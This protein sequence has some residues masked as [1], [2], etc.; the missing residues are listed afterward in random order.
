MK[1]IS[2]NIFY[3][4][5]I[6]F[7]VFLL[8]SFIYKDFTYISWCEDLFEPHWACTNLNPFSDINVFSNNPHHSLLY[9]M[10]YNLM[11]VYLPRILN[12]HPLTCFENITSYFYCFILITLLMVISLNFSI[13]FKKYKFII[14]FIIALLF[15][16]AYIAIN[17][18]STMYYIYYSRSW[19]CGYFI[20]PVFV[21]VLFLEFSKHFILE[22]Q[23]TRRNMI[24][25]VLL[26]LC[27][28][29][30]FE[31]LRYI[32]LTFLIIRIF[33]YIVAE[34][35]KVNLKKYLILL[36]AYIVF[37]FIL[38]LLC[39]GSSYIH[40]INLHTD[41]QLLIHYFRDFF[42]SYYHYIIYNNSVTLIIT[43]I[44]F[45][46]IFFFVKD[47]DRK[48][49]FY[50]YTGS[51][52]TAVFSYPLMTIFFNFNPEGWQYDSYFHYACDH[53]GT[54]YVTAIFMVCIL[55]SSFGF[56]ISHAQKLKYKIISSVILI[57]ALIPS[58]AFF[59]R[60]HFG[61]WYQLINEPE[62]TKFFKERRLNLY[63]LEKFYAMYGV[64]NNVFYTYSP[65]NVTY[66][67]NMIMYLLLL[68]SE[69]NKLGRNIPEAVDYRII[70]VCSDDDDLFTV[71]KDKML[72]TVKEKTGYV[73]TDEE[74]INTDFDS[75][76]DY[77]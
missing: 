28:A 37:N 17:D 1:K 12:I 57:F 69:N 54:R 59:V 58:Y 63:I 25:L 68:Y 47:N 20:L 4:L 15:F 23:L 22:Q 32:V 2:L 16:P 52:I 34:K 19:M 38:V 33:L 44:I 24:T 21:I 26:L 56:L 67:D 64:K 42:R 29:N 46:L 31:I 55:L 60:N 39:R 35:E 43:T 11:E 9:S 6:L 36:S 27:I 45:V 49:K 70:H 13:F 66:Y 10:P 41:P 48:N 3:I 30:S 75:I 71:C 61:T 53:L 5:I 62:F 40:F 18:L 8:H 50:L 65:H 14:C 74:L 76:K 51:L 72:K 77:L 73:F 7:G